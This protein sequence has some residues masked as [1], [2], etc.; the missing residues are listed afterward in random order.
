MEWKG[1]PRWSCGRGRRGGG[2]LGVKHLAPVSG[3]AV[4]EGPDALPALRDVEGASGAG[5][6]HEDLPEAVLTAATLEL[7]LVMTLWRQNRGREGASRVISTNNTAIN[8]FIKCY[9]KSTENYRQTRQ[10]YTT[11]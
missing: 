7:L 1:G 2:N 8:V 10:F 9:V 6:R 3:A 5:V 11:F 4:A